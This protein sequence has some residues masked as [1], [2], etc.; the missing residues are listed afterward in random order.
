MPGLGPRTR[1]INWI[2]I[3]C[4]RIAAFVV[5]RTPDWRC[6][7]GYP[8]PEVKETFL[9]A[10]KDGRNKIDPKT[11]ILELRYVLEP[12]HSLIP[13]HADL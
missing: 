8:A 9:K 11:G 6:L 4:K 7:P 5:L 13:D 2:K 3:G 12:Y 10:A 1:F